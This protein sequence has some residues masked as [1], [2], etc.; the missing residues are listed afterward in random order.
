MIPGCV[1]G[2]WYLQ[3]TTTMMDG[4]MFQPPLL[5]D[6]VAQ[7]RHLDDAHA[8]MHV[9][10]HTHTY[11]HTHIHTHTHNTHIHT[12]THKH[13]ERETHTDLCL[14]P[15]FLISMAVHLQ[16]LLLGHDLSEVSREAICVIQPP[17]H[18][19]WRERGKNGRLVDKLIF[20]K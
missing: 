10:T 3:Q 4:W 13:T 8:R 16:S 18:I 2:G 1:E 6:L 9:H 12:Q 19:T 7:C 14:L 15:S 20:H 17:H 11:T 5:G